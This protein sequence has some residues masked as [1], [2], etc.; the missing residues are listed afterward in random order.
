MYVYSKCCFFFSS[1]RRHT[2]CALV[3]G[4]QTCALPISMIAEEAARAV[5]GVTNSEGGGAATGRSQMALATSHG[6]AGAYAGT[7]H[8]TWAS[9]LAGTGADMQRDHASHSVRHIVDLDDADA[10][11]TRAGRRAVARDRKSTRLNSSH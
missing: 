7:S 5:P 1:R 2:R 6:F 3:T 4:V 9:V 11:G 8:S 10:V